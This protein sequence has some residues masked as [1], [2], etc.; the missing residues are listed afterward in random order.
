MPVKVGVPQG[1]ILGPFLFIVYVNDLPNLVEKYADIILYADDT[2]LVFKSSRKMPTESDVNE[3][4][5]KVKFWFSA[6]NL[7]LNA[8][9]TKCVKFSL[10]VNSVSD[11]SI[12]IDEDALS[13]DKNCTFLGI[14]LD[15][16]FQWAPHI[17]ALSSRLSSAAY[18]VRKIRQLTDFSTAKLVYYSYFHSLM[19]YGLLLWGEAADAGSISILQKRA[20]RAVYNLSSRT[21]LREKFKEYEIITMPGL[22]IL[23]NILYARKNLD[24]LPKNSVRHEYNT[25]NKEKLCLNKTRLSKVSKSFISNCIR[26]YNKIPDKIL[27]LTDKKFKHSLKSFLISRAY[28]KLEDFFNDNLNDYE[29]ICNKTK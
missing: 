9:K 22:Y 8:K 14:T 12:K 25:R 10:C 13:F 17:N 11:S 27:I 7:A 18:A 26:C 4:L 3:V 5:S 23:Q 20:V 15:S 28:Y 2:S 19:S 29:W 1:S 6:N 21:S 16:K 24:I